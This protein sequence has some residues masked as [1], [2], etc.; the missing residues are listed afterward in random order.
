MNSFRPAGAIAAAVFFTAGSAAVADVTADQVWT[1]WKAYMTQMGATVTAD[2]TKTA[3]G[4]D[5]ANVTMT[6]PVPEDGGNAVM[7]LPEIG[8]VDN[9]DGTVSITLPERMPLTVDVA[10]D[11]PVKAEVIYTAKD[12]KMT[13]SGDPS[14]MTYAYTA[15]SVGL[16]LGKISVKGE[17]VEI[18][19]AEMTMADIKGQT[20]MSGSDMR[21]AEQAATSGMVSYALDFTDPEE[22]ANHFK[23]DGGVESLE[24]TATT[25][26]PAGTS[27]SDMNAALKAGFAVYGQ[28]KFGPSHSNVSVNEEGKSTG[29]S[30][31][32][33]GG[34]LSIEMDKDHLRYGGTS[35]DLSTRVTSSELPFPIALEM[36]K[37][38]A[39]LSI[40]VMKS[41][42]PQDFAL[43]LAL[44]DFTVNDEVWNLF[45]PAGELP[46]DPATLAVD[47]EG[48]G[49]LSAD[50]MDPA[51]MAASEKP[52]AMPVALNALT[53]KSLL[54]RAAGAELTGKGDLTFN[55]DGPAPQPIG[56][57][58]LKLTGANTLLDKLIKMGLVPEEQAMG[59]R[60][61]MGVFA[62]PGDGEDELKSIIEF[63]E[64]GQIKANGQRIK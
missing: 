39:D 22:A 57:V 3:D 32:S 6:F 61:M 46:H 63:T 14:E 54:L 10:G 26:I 5:V 2:E 7:T 52:D 28:Y 45:D 34:T 41:D 60:M 30:S 18:G 64:D 62:V 50:L 37:A 21:S 27:F 58:D 16:A 49:T 9:G 31:R 38:T 12:L 17:P 56:D 25:M 29:A 51:Q 1:D 11:D 20:V 24:F 59:A 23:M 33:A 42:T 15:G 47:L 48:K 4:I 35:S 40:P 36:K 19:K 13:V 53:L 44:N 55:N 43:T 8:F